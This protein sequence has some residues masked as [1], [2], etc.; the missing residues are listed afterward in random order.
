MVKVISIISPTYQR[1]NLAHLGIVSKK[2]LE[3]ISPGSK[4]IFS[5]GK[6]I[7]M[8]K[9]VGKK[10]KSKQQKVIKINNA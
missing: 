9:M 4:Y 10:G 1:W 8:K 7:L 3:K 2:I 5:R 6:D